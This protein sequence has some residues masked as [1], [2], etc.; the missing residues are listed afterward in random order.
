MLKIPEKLLISPVVA[1]S[2]EIA[3]VFL[4]NLDIFGKGE[5]DRVGNLYTA[6]I[7]VHFLSTYFVSTPKTHNVLFVDC[8]RIFMLRKD[9]R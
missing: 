7:V 8:I 3:H 5:N 2:S 4:D 9:E 6:P 1:K